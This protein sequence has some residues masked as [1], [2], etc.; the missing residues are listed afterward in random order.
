M[1]SK[2]P[3]NWRFH[4]TGESLLRNNPQFNWSYEVNSKD[5]KPYENHGDKAQPLRIR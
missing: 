5:I 1:C 4:L 2:S 3:G